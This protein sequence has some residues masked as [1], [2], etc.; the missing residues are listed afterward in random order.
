MS[1]PALVLDIVD[2]QTLESH[3]VPIEKV[4]L[5]RRSGRYPALCGA[6]VVAASLATAPVRKCQ[7]CVLRSNQSNAPV[8]PGPA[9]RSSA[10][11]GGHR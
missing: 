8:Q 9:R 3:R 7:L 6:E 11:R 1:G 10:H 4:P 2:G 5:H